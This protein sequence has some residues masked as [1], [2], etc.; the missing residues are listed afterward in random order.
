MEDGNEAENM[1]LTVN[2]D[3]RGIMLKTQNPDFWDYSNKCFIAFPSGSL[4]G[5]EMW[6][7]ENNTHDAGADGRD[8]YFILPIPYTFS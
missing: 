5:P 8:F 4:N 6:F 3:D 7:S 2:D 1:T